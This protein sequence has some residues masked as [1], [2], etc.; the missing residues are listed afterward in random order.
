M[1]FN[2][3]M[4]PEQ[5]VLAEYLALNGSKEFYSRW[6]K[7]VDAFMGPNTAVEFI[8]EFEKKYYAKET[9]YEFDKLD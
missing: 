1:S 8:E 9:N 5:L 6:I 4:L 3:R 2:K 7:S